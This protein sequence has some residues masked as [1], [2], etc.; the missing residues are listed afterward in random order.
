MKYTNYYYYYYYYYFKLHN[1]PYI[2]KVRTSGYMTSKLIAS[3]R[4]A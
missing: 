4:L 2:S 1:M 3:V